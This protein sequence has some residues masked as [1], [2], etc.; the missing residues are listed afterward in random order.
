MTPR[1]L[2]AASLAGPAQP[3]VQGVDSRVFATKTELARTLVARAQAS[4]LPVSWVTADALYGQDWHFRRILGQRPARLRLGRRP[5]AGRLVLR[6]RRAVT[7][8]VGDGPPQHQPSRRDRLLPRP[9]P[10]RNRRRQA[11]RSRLAEIRRLLAARHPGPPHHQ[12]RHVDR[13]L[14]WSCCAAT[15]RPPPGTATTTPHRRSRTSP[16]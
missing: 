12:P 8:Q 5:V 16:T 11:R 3:A 10:H 9:R 2:C 13:A 6:Q 1:S 7:P 15:I 4:P 14:R